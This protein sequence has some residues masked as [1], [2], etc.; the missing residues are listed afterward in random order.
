MYEKLFVIIQPRIIAQPLSP[1]RMSKQKKHLSSNSS[2]ERSGAI[3]PFNSSNSF[4]Q[5]P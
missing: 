4:R 5:L 2:A 1:L 3:T